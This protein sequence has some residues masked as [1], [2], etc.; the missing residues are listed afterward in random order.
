MTSLGGVKLVSLTWVSIGTSLRRL[1]LVGL[2]YVP[3]R[4]YKD[5]SIGP[6]HSRT[7][8][9]VAMTS[10]HGPQRL[11]LYETK[12]RRRYDVAC[13]VGCSFERQKWN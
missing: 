9:D 5:V 13:R 12:M 7:S 10:Q 6:P 11:D 2:N 1:K 3:M 4:R 8:R